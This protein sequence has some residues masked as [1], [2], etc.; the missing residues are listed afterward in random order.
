MRSRCQ[1]DGSTTVSLAGAGKA[2]GSDAV[3]GAVVANGSGAN[4]VGAGASSQLDLE[5]R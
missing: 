5:V 2:A 4:G 1:G 3:R